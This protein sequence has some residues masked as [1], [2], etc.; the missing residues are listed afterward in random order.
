MD[1]LRVTREVQIRNPQGLHARPANEFVKL[2]S[3]YTSKIEIVCGHE[4]VDGKSILD[5][6]TLA[7]GFGT[8]LRVEAQGQDAEAAVEALGSLLERA[9]EPA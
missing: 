2:A 8:T 3:R 9:E 1:E 6:L 7:A 5:L 4:R